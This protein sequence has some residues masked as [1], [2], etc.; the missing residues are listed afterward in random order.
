MEQKYQKL[1][2]HQKLRVPTSEGSV[3]FLITFLIPMGLFNIIFCDLCAIS[4]FI[5]IYS[6]GEDVNLNKILFGTAI[7]TV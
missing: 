1:I 4:V 5:Q 6:H 3:L 2:F 7:G